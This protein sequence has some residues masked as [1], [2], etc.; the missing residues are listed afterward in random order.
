MDTL[1][2][3]EVPGTRRG[4]EIE[5]NE[6]QQ[7]MGQNFI[8]GLMGNLALGPAITRLRDEKDPAREEWFPENELSEDNT[9]GENALVAGTELGYQMLAGAGV[10]LGGTAGEA[11]YSKPQMYDKL[12]EGIPYHMHG[13]IMRNDNLEAAQRARERIIERL[14]RGHRM[15]LQKGTGNTLALMAGSLVDIDMPLIFMTGGGYGSAR[16]ARAGLKM[17]EKFGMSR[18]ASSVSTNALIGTSAG[19]QAGFIAGVGGVLW[20]ET[21]DWT[22]VADAAL[23]AAAMGGTFGAV[24]RPDWGL[25]IREAQKELYD[26]MSRNDP[27]LSGQGL[28]ADDLYVY[29]PAFVTDD[30]PETPGGTVIL[31]APRP[32]VP[33]SADGKQVLDF[34]DASA[35]ARQLPTPSNSPIRLDRNQYNPAPRIKD[36]T[37]FAED[38]RFNTGWQDRKIAEQDEWLFKFVTGGAGRGM[39]KDIAQLLRSEAPSANFLGGAVFESPHGYGR[40]H[41]VAAM[42]QDQYTK[43]LQSEFLPVQDHMMSWA[44]RHNHALLGNRVHIS[45]AGQEAFGREVILEINARNMDR[46]YSKDADVLGAA[47]AI[48]R[49]TDLAIKVGRGRP[50]QYGIDGFDTIRSR[51]YYPQVWQGKKLRDLIRRGVIDE[52]SVSQALAN[53]YRQAGMLRTKDAQA[54]ADAVVARMLNSADDFPGNLTDILNGDGRAYMEDMLR[55][56]GMSRGR[57]KGIIDRISRNKDDA[58][59][60][61]EVKHRN[62]IDLEYTIPTKD[63]S[64]LQIVDLL[65]H[66]VTDV[67]TRYNR[68]IAGSAG[69]ARVGLTNRSMRETV[70][71]AIQKEQE[72]LGEQA[73]DPNLLRAMFTEFDGGPAH[74]Y[75]QRQTTP[76]TRPAVALAKRLTRLSLLQ[77]LGAAQLAETGAQMAAIGL[78]NWAHRAITQRISA[79]GRAQQQALKDDLAFMTGRI[80]EDQRFLAQHLD[81]DSV[82]T[83]DASTWLQFA[84]RWSAK[85]EY[86]QSY[87]SAFN[88]I[89]GWQQTTAALGITDKV[90]LGIRDGMA[91]GISDTLRKRLEFD[92]GIGDTVISDIE[93]LIKDGTIEFGSTSSGKSFV[94]RLN[95]DKWESKLGG[96]DSLDLFSQGITRSVNQQVQRSMAGESDAWMRTE[97]AGLL[98]QLKMFPLQAISKQATRNLRFA[99]MESLTALTAGLATAYLAITIR[100]MHDNRDRSTM[101]TAKAAF[102]YSNMTGFIP[103]GFDPVMSALGLHDLRFNQYGP[104]SEASV[105]SVDA[106]NRL[107]RS[108]GGMAKFV[109][110]EADY[111][112]RQAAMAWPFMNMWGL[113]AMFHHNR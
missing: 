95:M 107:M 58:G 29:R 53:G 64:N 57:I 74:G 103:M 49:N 36:F 111:N 50:G 112:D 93:K 77:K 44:K 90:I 43:R 7:T 24:V 42:Y 11:D 22:M 61:R 65:N 54:V 1:R 35:G 80:G 82:S 88:H 67:M 84:Q 48:Q 70:I 68:R 16:L 113:S 71:S 12:T 32:T 5:A 23:M 109:V 92:F 4:A 79:M 52:T 20:D 39:A 63:G 98:M 47:N 105:A 8:D 87:T 99:D 75:W 85:A 100:D 78:Q 83:Q 59:K 60:L 37:E 76:G 96:V 102:G 91:D 108:P 26:R 21:A 30:L 66:D 19:F 38:W 10:L 25:Q 81:M 40:G 14:E 15:G 17:N 55:Q 34:Q 94:N 9:W 86:I 110:G 33:Y 6:A 46:T 18:L 3:W 101:D 2:S 56:A 41:G 73:V 72:F 27:N 45:N 89:R 31:D 106:M 28:N 51:P 97:A 104:Y 69:L 13:S 62:E